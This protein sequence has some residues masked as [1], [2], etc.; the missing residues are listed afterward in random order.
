MICFP[1]IENAS[2]I[3]S[4]IWRWSRIHGGL[5]I[6]RLFGGGSQ[7]LSYFFIFKAFFAPNKDQIHESQWGKFDY[8][9]SVNPII[10]RNIV[11]LNELWNQRS[12][13]LIDPCSAHMWSRADWKTP[14]R[15]LPFL[16][17]SRLFYFQ[18]SF[19]KYLSTSTLMKINLGNHTL[20]QMFKRML[21]NWI[22]DRT[23]LNMITKALLYS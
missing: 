14:L 9:L 22:N 3:Q 7:C 10:K 18:F 23:L 19:C 20:D 11:I 8:Q 4:D 16:T 2:G 17:R 21:E 15:C 1:R 6:K 5:L 12:Q 13:M